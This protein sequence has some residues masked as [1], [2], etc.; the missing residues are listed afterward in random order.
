MGE[1][2]VL[3]TIGDEHRAGTSVVS[4]R[5]E[6][7]AELANR[8]R[9]T[10]ANSFQSASDLAGDIDC[11]IA[12]GRTADVS[13]DD[14]KKAALRAVTGDWLGDVGFLRLPQGVW[15][16]RYELLAQVNAESEREQN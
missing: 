14:E 15:S 3:F 7:A 6:D 11:V 4:V 9:G 8:L 12:K 10:S 5:F 1:K 2:V 13:L 16:L